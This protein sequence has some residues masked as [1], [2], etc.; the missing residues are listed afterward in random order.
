LGLE[1]FKPVGIRIEGINHISSSPVESVL[2]KYQAV[3]TPNLGCYT[4]EPVS[5]DLDPSV[6]PVRMKAR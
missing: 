6:P 2:R 1:W 5:L 4:G 3:F